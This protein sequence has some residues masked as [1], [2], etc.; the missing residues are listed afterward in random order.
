MF[1]ASTILNRMFFVVFHNAPA[2]TLKRAPESKAPELYFERCLIGWLLWEFKFS[3]LPWLVGGW[4]IPLKNMS[5]LGWLE[6]Q[7]FWE[8]FWTIDGNQT[9]NQMIFP[10]LP[11]NP[12]PNNPMWCFFPRHHGEMQREHISG[13][14]IIGASCWAGIRVHQNEQL[15]LNVT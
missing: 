1:K 13:I 2:A 3:S 10:Y 9:T 14:T 8:N 5:Q 4:A 7:Y 6:T 11:Y 12:L 15:A